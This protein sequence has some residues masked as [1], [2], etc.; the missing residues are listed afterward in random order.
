MIHEA[1]INIFSSSI[2]S[3]KKL[4]NQQRAFM[5]SILIHMASHYG[6]SG[7]LIPSGLYE[8]TCSVQ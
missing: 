5:T 8:G 2:Q 7:K 4:K 1:W 3:S 6:A